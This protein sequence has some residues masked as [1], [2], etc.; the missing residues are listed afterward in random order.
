MF[1]RQVSNFLRFIYY[2]LGTIV[3]RKHLP[4]NPPH[5]KQVHINFGH[6]SHFVGC[7]QFCVIWLQLFSAHCS[8]PP[9]R[10][11]VSLCHCVH[12]IL[13]LK[14]RLSRKCLAFH[15]R[16]HII[17]CLKTVRV[18]AFYS[19]FCQNLSSCAHSFKILQEVYLL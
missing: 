13:N 16:S 3:V 5:S 1:C 2:F 9:C 6:R 4:A 17:S 11:G 8:P 7:D 14:F 15:K 10:V 12:L 19:C 18:I